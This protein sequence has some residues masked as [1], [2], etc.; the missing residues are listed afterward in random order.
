MAV[1]ELGYFS[2]IAILDQS[3]E[4][5][6]M[7][8]CMCSGLEY[9]LELG[10]HSIDRRSEVTTDHVGSPKIS[11]ALATIMQP[12]ATSSLLLPVLFAFDD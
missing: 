3:V 12:F 2:A 6:N 4:E 1:G 5:A 11:E 8:R 7:N 10:Q 9:V